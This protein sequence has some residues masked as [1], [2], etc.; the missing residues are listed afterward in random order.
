[1]LWEQEEI[2]KRFKGRCQGCRICDGRRCAGQ[3]P[4]MGGVGRGLCF[5]ANVKALQELKLNLRVIHDV[6][7]VD[8]SIELFG[9]R[10]SIPILG[11]PIAGAWRNLPDVITEEI[12]LNALLEGAVQAGTIGMT[13]GGVTPEGD[14]L[15]WVTLGAIKKN[16]GLGI[17]ILKPQSDKDQLLKQVKLAQELGCIA[18]GIDIDSPLSLLPWNAS[19]SKSVNSWQKIVEATN[20]PFI[21]KGVM[22]VEDAKAAVASGVSAIVVSN[23]GGRVIDCLPATATV[24][25]G[26]ARAVGEAITVLA[27]GGIR[28]GSD[29]LKMLALGAKAVLIGRP[30]IRGAVMEGAEGVKKTFEKFKT[31]LEEA[32]RLTGTPALDRVEKRVLYQN[33]SA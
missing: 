30:L 12:L 16:N 13:G 10:F 15:E 7:T 8:T 24:L 14:S 20:L 9:H 23:H 25:P 27:D 6:N 32:M 5:Q 26:I 1:M 2:R 28:F 3:V 18:V 33:E 4:G 17:P 29:V 11:A 31:E 22:S 19:E 21:F